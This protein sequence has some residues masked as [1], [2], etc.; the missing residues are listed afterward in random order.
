V[1]QKTVSLREAAVNICY[2]CINAAK[3][4][5]QPFLYSAHKRYLAQITPL[6]YVTRSQRRLDH[7]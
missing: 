7:L 6:V 5:G 3:L 2:T 4:A 1:S